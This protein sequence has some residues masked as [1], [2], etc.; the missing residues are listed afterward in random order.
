MSAHISSTITLNKIAT[1]N[2]LPGNLTCYDFLPYYFHIPFDVQTKFQCQVAFTFMNVSLDVF[3]WIIGS[4][5][6]KSELFYSLDVG[7]QKTNS[8]QLQNRWK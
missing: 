5:Y 3:A 7:V 6:A 4:K 2:R 8:N 1:E